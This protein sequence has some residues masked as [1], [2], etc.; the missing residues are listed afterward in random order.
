MWHGRTRHYSSGEQQKYAICLPSE[1]L[2]A[3]HRVNQQSVLK[4]VTIISDLINR[5]ILKSLV[6]STIIVY[7]GSL[8]TGLLQVLTSNQYV[9]DNLE[10]P[11][12]A[13]FTGAECISYLAV[14]YTYGYYSG[15]S[16]DD[17]APVDGFVTTNENY[18]Q[19][20]EDY[21][22]DGT[23]VRV[24]NSTCSSDVPYCTATVKG[25]NASETYVVS[26]ANGYDNR[27]QQSTRKVYLAYSA[28][29]Q[30]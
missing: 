8:T 20:A 5:K 1:V 19:W 13:K 16:F 10:P 27:A 6:A 24:A 21:F 25:L 7:T 22:P 18:L 12:T 30:G 26:V 23:A 28:G 2:K 14:G 17:T 15:S 9:F 3:A 4:T 29:S 11:A